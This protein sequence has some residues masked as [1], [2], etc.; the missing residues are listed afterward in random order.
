MK[1]FRLKKICL[2]DIYSKGYKITERKFS[3]YYRKYFENSKSKLSLLCSSFCKL[4]VG[5][6][7]VTTCN[8]TRSGVMKS[9]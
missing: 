6:Q 8:K 5:H 2:E 9:I 3:I 1:V 7:T 4:K